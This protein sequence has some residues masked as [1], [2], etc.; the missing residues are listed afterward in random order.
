MLGNYRLLTAY[1]NGG[2]KTIPKF[3]QKF[4]QKNTNNSKTRYVAPT[5]LSYEYFIKL[6]RWK[7]Y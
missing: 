7:N 1:K 3:T 4:I 2:Y 5:K 6:H